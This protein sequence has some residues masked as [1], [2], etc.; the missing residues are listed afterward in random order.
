MLLAHVTILNYSQFNAEYQE[1]FSLLANFLGRE[2][3]DE[4]QKNVPTGSGD[5]KKSGKLLP[6]PDG[7]TIMY[8]T[9]YA[10]YVHEGQPQSATTP[11]VSQIPRHIR[12]IKGR[13]QR[14]SLVAGVSITMTEIKLIPI[15]EHTKTYKPGFKPMKR[16]DGTWTTK[17]VTANKDWIQQAYKIK[18]HGFK[19]LFKK[20]FNLEALLPRE[21]NIQNEPTPT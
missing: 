2:V 20:D 6:A 5:L 1:R 11:H 3:F 18:W 16:S 17:A 21:I 8:N 14:I 19:E 15:K 12:Q 13:S 9:P 4:A 7:F 10:Y